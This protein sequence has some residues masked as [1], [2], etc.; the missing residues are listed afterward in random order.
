MPTATRPDEPAAKEVAPA[1][2]KEDLRYDGRPFSDWRN[3]WRTELKA[4]R[5]IDFLRAMAAFGMN[6]YAEEAT[7]ATIELV[8]TYGQDAFEAS[9]NEPTPDERVVTEAQSAIARIGRHAVPALLRNLESPSA[10]EFAKRMIWFGPLAKK[11][12]PETAVPTLVSLATNRNREIRSLAFWILGESV[13]TRPDLKAKL[14]H[15]IRDRSTAGPFF[16]AL[17]T[18]LKSEDHDYAADI[19]QAVGGVGKELLPVVIE[20]LTAEAKRCKEEAA[21]PRGGYGGAVSQ[22][23][24]PAEGKGIKPR[25]TVPLWGFAR[26]LIEWLGEL[27]PRAKSAV[28]TL[29]KLVDVADDE[30]RAVILKTLG[31][32]GASTRKAPPTLDRS[33][34]NQTRNVQ[35]ALISSYERATGW[36][37]LG[38]YKLKAH[39]GDFSVR[40]GFLTAG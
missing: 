2:K 35:R 37:L 31:R 10:R 30:D 18:A 13:A 28:P 19:L 17:G 9:H 36:S 34:L 27:G 22:A 20:V 12:L 23:R 7:K 8:T 29:M 11:E 38:K 1:L 25:Q 5:R 3:Y 4:E 14:L 33:F 24:D 32:I 15:T 16:S 40:F 26:V 21:R 6:G 39:T